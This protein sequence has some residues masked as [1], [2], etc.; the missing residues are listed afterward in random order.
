MLSPSKPGLIQS[1]VWIINW[2]LLP[3]RFPVKNLKHWHSP[4]RRGRKFLAVLLAMS[5]AGAGLRAAIFDFPAQYQG[6]NASA[7]GGNV[8][9][10]VFDEERLMTKTHN[11]GS[12]VTF[13]LSVVD[14][15]VVW[16]SASI[17]YY[18]T[19][20]AIAGSWKGESVNSAPPASNLQTT[21]GIVTWST[22]SGTIYYRVFDRARGLWRTGSAATGPTSNLGAVDGTV[23][24]T[25]SGSAHARVYA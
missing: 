22:T 6:V 8:T 21:N 2:R 7:G 1:M 5:L 16:S 19:Y 10:S 4:S 3:A 9:M 13:D 20:D 17:V 24:W 11:V 14:G 18:Y 25:T 12:G 15:D 23:A